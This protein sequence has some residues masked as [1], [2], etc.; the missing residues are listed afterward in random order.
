M[1]YSASR[2][3]EINYEILDRLLIT[4]VTDTDGNIVD[5]SK[6][7][8]AVS[9]YRKEELLGQNHR[10]MRHPDT[11]SEIFTH[12]WNTI[13]EGNI[14]RG[15]IKNRGKYG[16]DFWSSVHIE[17]IR[18]GVTILGYLALRTNIT[19]QRELVRQATTDALTGIYN[20]SK[21]NL[22]L[23]HEAEQAFRY[24]YDLS[25]LFIDLDHFK[26][27]NDRFGHSEGD[28][29]LIELAETISQVLRLSDH[30]GRWGGEEFLII[31]SKTSIDAVYVLAEKLRTQVMEHDFRLGMA[32]TLSIGISRYHPDMSLEETI[33]SADG[34][35][36][37]AKKQGR[38]QTVLSRP[39]E[40]NE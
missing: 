34:A 5:V 33:R 30:F 38:N 39:K 32:V 6:G 31:A 26:K 36:Y 13:K 24:G 23:A 14:W 21:L 25:L 2:F 35:M 11:P 29:V 27:I 8:E 3:K 28:R 4:T 7:F 40:R 10:I 18:S 1:D 16:N 9:G 17:P 37:A 20:R 19:E 12:L 15:E 22:L